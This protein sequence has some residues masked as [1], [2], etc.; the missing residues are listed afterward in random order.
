MAV[1]QGPHE[2]W[3]AEAM[4]CSPHPTYKPFPSS[5]RG[6]GLRAPPPGGGPPLEVPVAGG[7]WGLPGDV[8]QMKCE[9]K[10]LA[11]T[12]GDTRRLQWSR[13]PI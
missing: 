5:W 10:R 1:S 12:G 7:L 13:V 4:A 8:S 9:D 3:G 11:N 2:G 6:K